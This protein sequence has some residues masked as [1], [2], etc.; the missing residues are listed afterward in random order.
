MQEVLEKS[1]LLHKPGTQE[2]GQGWQKLAD[3]LNLIDGFIVTSRAVQDK[4][5]ALIK[6]HRLTIN[7]EKNTN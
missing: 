2:R 6:K 4:I 7:K 3:N 5:M 1:I